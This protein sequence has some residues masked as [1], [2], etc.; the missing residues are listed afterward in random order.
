MIVIASDLHSSFYALL[1]SEQY[2]YSIYLIM[3]L[4]FIEKHSK[5]IA[6]SP[7]ISETDGP[8]TISTPSLPSVFPF[9]LFWL[10]SVLQTH[11]VLHGFHVFVKAILP[12]GPLH[13]PPF[14]TFAYIHNLSVHF[15]SFLLFI[16]YS[17]TK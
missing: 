15:Q 11:Q 3:I 8:L 9:Q 4:S 5:L 13:N 6:L 7:I 2:F 17:L 10:H 1:Q 14:R 12:A 16:H